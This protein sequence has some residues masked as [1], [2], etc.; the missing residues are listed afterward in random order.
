M[1]IIDKQTVFLEQGEVAPCFCVCGE[2]YQPEKDSKKSVCPKC[3]RIN[4]HDV[5]P[6]IVAEMRH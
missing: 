6:G 5:M 2:I 4:T 3:H 1:R